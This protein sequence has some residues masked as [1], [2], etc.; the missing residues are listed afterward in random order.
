MVSRAVLPS[1]RGPRCPYA[2]TPSGDTTQA[3]SFARDPAHVAGAW[4]PRHSTQV[5]DVDN[6]EQEQIL[7]LRHPKQRE[8]H[9]HV[10]LPD[11]KE[12]RIGASM[13]Q[14]PL[15]LSALQ[16]WHNQEAPCSTHK[17]CSTRTCTLLARSQSSSSAASVRNKGLQLLPQTTIMMPHGNTVYECT[18]VF[19][20][21]S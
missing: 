11:Y 4:G 17:G 13:Y 21:P 18:L 7:V 12:A 1:Q 10:L 3:C 16:G 9:Q 14:M 8:D 20:W 6:G 15:R 19:V 5:D 2:R